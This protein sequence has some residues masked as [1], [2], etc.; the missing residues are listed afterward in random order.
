[1]TSVSLERV[2]F[3]DQRRRMVPTNATSGLSRGAQSCISRTGSGTIRDVK[4]KCLNDSCDLVSVKR[5]YCINHYERLRRAGKL[6]KRSVEELY[7]SKVDRSGGPDACHPWTRALN[8][9][10]YGLFA[11][12]GESL[13]ARWAYKRFVGPLKPGEMVRHT[14]DNPPCQNRRHWLK[15]TVVEN[16]RDCVERERQWRPQGEVNVKARLTEDQVR[17]IRDDAVTPRKV[18]AF[19]YSVSVP[20]ICSIQNRA[21]WKHVA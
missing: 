20:T 1:M 14:C 16:S 5:G 9:A 11:H 10:G 6:P 15:G 2:A 12:D 18:L 4:P 3:L 17:Q 8:K 19:Q 7:E 21:T 13:A